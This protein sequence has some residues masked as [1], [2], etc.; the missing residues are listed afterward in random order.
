MAPSSAHRAE[1][2]SRPR[3][4]AV[5]YEDPNYNVQLP[6]FAIHGDHDDPGGEGGLS[7]L[8]AAAALEL[9]NRG[10][11]VV[12]VETDATGAQARVPLP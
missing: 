7:A 12:T 9:T 8:V 2:P 5:N 11:T 1:P 10:V 6:V 4:G 3:Y